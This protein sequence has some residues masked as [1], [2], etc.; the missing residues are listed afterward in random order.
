MNDSLKNIIKLSNLDKEQTSFEDKKEEIRVELNN[1]LREKEKEEIS[2]TSIKE[3][4]EDSKTNIQKNNTYI[5]E[6]NEKITEIAVKN[7]KVKTEKE[8]KAL[9]IEEDIAKEQ[10]IFTNDEI[11]RY[12][13]ILEN[14]SS[15]LEDAKSKI[16][17]VDKK[18]KKEEK[19]VN[20][21]I[22]EIDEG[23]SKSNT[24]KKNLVKKVD[25]KTLSFYNK[26]RQWADDSSVVSINDK[27][28]NGCHVML[29][30]Q[31]YIEVLRQNEITTCP[32]CGRI[33][34]IDKIQKQE[35]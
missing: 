35:K 31:S 24:T 30:D 11:A 19:Q 26:I 8:L 15:E 9:S 7:A 20:L 32:N 25:E 4:E 2:I 13:K 29:N 34:Y 23:I 3:K 22:Q 33:V 17:D 21:S 5:N 6:L 1:L 28:C 10:L 12:E 14:I 27:V 18:I 16:K